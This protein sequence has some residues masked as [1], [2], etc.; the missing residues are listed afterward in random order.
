MVLARS[1]CHEIE[2]PPIYKFQTE[3]VFCDVILIEMNISVFVI[4]RNNYTKYVFLKN[5]YHG[6]F[7]KNKPKFLAKQVLGKTNAS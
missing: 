2:V 7:L 1:Y 5:R 4:Y 3:T 6:I